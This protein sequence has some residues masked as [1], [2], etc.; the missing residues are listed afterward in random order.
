MPSDIPQADTQELDL[1]F[2]RL[3]DLPPEAIW[4]AW[5]TPALVTQ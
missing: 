2:E 3:V 5:T 4:Q 1:V